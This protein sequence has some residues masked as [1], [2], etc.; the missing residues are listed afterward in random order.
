MAD[1]CFAD[2]RRWLTM[3]SC[4]G[5]NQNRLRT[6]QPK[7]SWNHTRVLGGSPYTTIQ[8]LDLKEGVVYQPGQ[9]HNCLMR[10]SRSQSQPEVSKPGLGLPEVDPGDAVHSK[11]ERR[12]KSSKSKS[13]LR[14]SALD[15]PARDEYAVSVGRIPKLFSARALFGEPVVNG[16]VTLV[17]VAKL[18]GG[19]GFGGG[20][21]FEENG[22]GGGFGMDSR[23]I[24]AY[25]MRGD[26][27]EWVPARQPHVTTLALC[28]VASLAI[29]TLRSVL[30]AR[31]K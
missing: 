17:P 13:K 16:S 5:V 24:G 27:V 8:G 7:P 20:S 28:G 18:V 6:H 12:K 1:R 21:G 31:L 15:Q 25:V 9:R 11:G 2:R 22:S 10:D 14:L 23:G 3:T 29:L 19:G 4:L 26:S 30:K